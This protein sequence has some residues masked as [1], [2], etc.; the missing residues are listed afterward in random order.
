MPAQVMKLNDKF[1][2]VEP[3]GTVVKNSKGGP[4]D[5]GGHK[6]RAKA[7]AQADAININQSSKGKM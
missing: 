1:R 4:V 7:Q 6:T 3:N 2:V 5:G